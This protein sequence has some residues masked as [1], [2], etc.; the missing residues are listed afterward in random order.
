MENIYLL[1]IIALVILAIADLVVGVSNDAV[2]FLNSAIGSKAI[3][4]KGILIIASLG[5]FIG[6]GFSSG[7]MEV[8]RS[9]IFNPAAFTFDEVMI[10]FMAVMITDILLLDFFNTIGLPTSTTVSI[11]FEL[12]GAAV[13]IGLIK[14]GS[15]DTETFAQITNYINA[16]NVPRIISGIG[17]SVVIAFTC[18]S[19][20]QYITRLIFTF[21]S[22]KKM[23]YFG[24][25]FGG[26]ALTSITYFIF[27][28]GL[29]GTPFYQYIE[30]YL[31]GSHLGL[32]VVS[33]LVWT[34]FSQLFIRILKKDILIVVIGVGTFGLALA[35]AGNDLVNFLG[36]PVAAYHS[37]IDWSA[38]GVAP[39]EYLMSNLLESVPTE[40]L[41][42]FGAGIIMVLTLWFS[43]KA[44]T[45][46]E[47]EINLSRQD[48]AQEK[49]EPNLL[50]R[51]IVRGSTQAVAFVESLVP[52]PVLE[53]ISKRFEKPVVTLS[54]DKTVELPA[55]DNIRA[56]INMSVSGIFISTAFII[57]LTLFITY[58]YFIVY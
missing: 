52:K 32:I 51:V 56:S 19:V 46:T 3:P 16:S 5:V 33:F 29:K 6:A 31:Q 4:F 41:I 34:V 47:T 43:K 12:L 1:M 17:L 21:Q 15:S 37:Y 44:R 24:A 13:I 14:I 22:E 10:I 53:K 20:I 45:V 49:F 23:K 26:V 39:D 42:L 48:E 54:G 50:S 36:V 2:N 8:A 9:G 30:P 7:M 57:Q 40:S 28:K 25:L 27:I 35:F 18:G 58:N 11:V 38:S 55:F